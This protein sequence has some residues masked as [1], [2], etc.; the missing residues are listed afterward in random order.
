MLIFALHICFARAYPRHNHNAFTH[1]HTC[2]YTHAYPHI[3]SVTFIA[4]ACAKYA[5]LNKIN[6]RARS[7][8]S[9]LYDCVRFG[10]CAHVRR[11]T[12]GIN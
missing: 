9:D 1:N 7:V 4:G 10:S 2:A 6:K 5:S 3:I 12:H 8:I 11:E